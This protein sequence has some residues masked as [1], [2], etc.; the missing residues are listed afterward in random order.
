MENYDE[1]EYW[2]YKENS[3][4]LGKCMNDL[5]ESDTF[6]D[7]VIKVDDE[8]IKTHKIVLAAKCDMFRAMLR[9]NFKESTENEIELGYLNASRVRKVVEFIY[10]GSF[11][12]QRKCDLKELEKYI[13]G[14][15]LVIC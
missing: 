4:D 12:L 9:G 15:S 5:R 10:T 14:N 11:S 8:E 2:T 13:Q 3:N 7:F 1:E 6:C